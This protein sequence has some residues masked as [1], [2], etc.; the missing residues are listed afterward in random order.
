M[1]GPENGIGWCDFTWNPITGCLHGCTFGPT[2]VKCYAEVIA[3]RF[4]GS[5]A[6]PNGFDPTFHPER[7]GEPLRV[8][9]PARIFTCSMADLFGSWVPRAQIDAVLD[10]ITAAP[11]HTFQCLTKAPWIAKGIQMPDN[12]WLGGTVTGGLQRESH[13][14]DCI[15][16]YRARVRF[17]SYEPAEGPIDVARAEPDW[18]IIGAATGKGGF[19]P[20]DRWVRDVERWCDRNAVPVY[21]KDNLT[22]RADARREEFPDGQSVRPPG[23]WDRRSRLTD[24]QIVRFY[25]TPRAL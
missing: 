13:R 5:K 16:R 1:N 25:P 8:K 2:K 23:Y 22:I 10:A 14:L 15:R 24:E 21:H 20:E 6:F 12:I 9:T 17:I 7:L 19:Q 3:E 11:W 18:V 4:R